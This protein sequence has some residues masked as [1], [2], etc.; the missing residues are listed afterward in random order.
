MKRIH[1]CLLLLAAMFMPGA[2]AADELP[3]IIIIYADD[4]GYQD[5]SCSRSPNIKP[6]NID[7]IAM[8]GCRCT[9]LYSPY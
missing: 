7:R 2:A 5:P 6:S 8:A 4:Q 1:S 9:D 3:N